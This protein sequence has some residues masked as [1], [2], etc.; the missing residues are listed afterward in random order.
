[1]NKNLIFW[2]LF[3]IALWLLFFRKSEGCAC[4]MMIG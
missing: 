1:M 4:G 2:V 3:F